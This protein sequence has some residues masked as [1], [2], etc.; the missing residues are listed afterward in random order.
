MLPGPVSVAQ[1]IA[2]LDNVIMA[3]SLRDRFNRVNG[4]SPKPSIPDVQP[5]PVSPE[6]LPSWVFGGVLEDWLGGGWVHGPHGPAFIVEERVPLA[7]HHGRLR[8]E[9]AYRV[10]SQTIARFARLPEIAGMDTSRMVFLDIETTGLAGGAGTLPFLVGIGF[11]DGPDFVVRQY[12]VADPAL[13]LPMLEALADVIRSASALVTFNGRSFD[14]PML[15]TRYVFNRARTPLDL[16][17]IDLLMPSRRIWRGWLASCRLSSLEQHILELERGDDIP[18]ADIPGRYFRYLRDGRVDLMPSVLQ[19]NFWDVLSMVT[20]LA[21]ISRL[22]EGMP[23]D[24]TR[25]HL[26]CARLWETENEPGRAALAYRRALEGELSDI[27][28]AEAMTRLAGLYRRLGRWSDAAALWRS[29]IDRPGNLAVRPYI[30]LARYHE[31]R[32]REA[33]VALSLLRAALDLVRHYH[34]RVA[35]DQGALLRADIEVRITRLEQ[36]APA[37]R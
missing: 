17:N 7:A 25:G 35:P 31:R 18:G 32:L 33:D 13:E 2:R 8:L 16:P 3:Q 21:G 9:E 34:L 19:H 22:Y 1:A 28:R 30:E 4:P 36:K 15:E 11:R 5:L 37:A 20:L 6:T 10:A 29:L 26:I 12:F 14:V 24:S 27:E 23:Q